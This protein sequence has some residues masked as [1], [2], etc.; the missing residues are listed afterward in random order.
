M[1]LGSRFE[2]VRRGS[3]VERNRS[4]CHSLL[5]VSYFDVPVDLVRS[6]MRVVNNP[7][8][9]HGR[10]YWAASVFQFF[11]ILLVQISE[12]LINWRITRNGFLVYENF[13][14]VNIILVAV[15]AVD[16][17]LKRLLTYELLHNQVVLVHGVLQLT[18]KLLFVVV[19]IYR[20][21]PTTVA[22]RL[23]N[24]LW[25]DHWFNGSVLSAFVCG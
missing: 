16:T 23:H 25:W 12:D 1:H 11:L 3:R 7:L 21:G 14:L 20:G 8:V 10:R 18:E 19:D 4:S 13:G 17:R 6:H 9:D 24:V 22:E 2:M 15:E 5:F